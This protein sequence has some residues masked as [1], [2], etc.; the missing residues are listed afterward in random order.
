[1][2][3]WGTVLLT[4]PLPRP[5]PFPGLAGSG[6]SGVEAGGARMLEAGV[7]GRLPFVAASSGRG[8]RARL[9]ASRGRQRTGNVVEG[10]AELETPPGPGS[11]HRLPS[12]TQPAAGRC[13]GSE[14]P[15]GPGRVQRSASS[16]SR[17][18]PAAATAAPASHRVSN[19]DTG[20]QAT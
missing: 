10:L 7:G 3:G 13:R 16:R 20:P 8:C 2:R 5:P 1:M 17:P 11:A 6:G 4:P 18:F 9:Q 19:T 15:S 12:Q 14:G